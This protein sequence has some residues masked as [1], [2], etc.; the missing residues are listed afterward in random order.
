MAKFDVK[1]PGAKEFLIVGGVALAGFLVWQHFRGNSAAATP[2]ADTPAEAT[3]VDNSSPTGLSN[4]QLLL[5][6]TDHMRSTTTT[7]TTH[8]NPPPRKRV[9]RRKPPKIRPA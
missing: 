8:T 7:K 5:W 3:P 9:N 2:S 1:N 6:I 4:S